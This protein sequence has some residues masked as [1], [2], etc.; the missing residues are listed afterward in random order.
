[1]QSTAIP[2]SA[3]CGG[4][5][6]HSTHGLNSQRLRAPN[7]RWAKD[8]SRSARVSTAAAT[9]HIPPRVKHRQMSSRSH[10]DLQGHSPQLNTADKFCA[11]HAKSDT[12]LLTRGRECDSD[13]EGDHDNS[14][15]QMSSEIDNIL[16]GISSGLIMPSPLHIIPDPGVRRLS[17]DNEHSKNC[18]VVVVQLIIT[19]VLHPIS[20]HVECKPVN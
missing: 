13:D 3:R 9:N 7:A 17:S 2:L 20:M 16:Q 10:T 11:T 12:D 8:Y 14:V 6:S 18:V 4:S 15:D 5:T 1:M 19:L